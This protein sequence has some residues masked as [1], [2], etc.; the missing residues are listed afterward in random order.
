MIGL[1]T[2]GGPELGIAL[3]LLLR[4]TTP[5]GGTI[6]LGGTRGAGG[7][8]FPIPADDLIE[9]PP[10]GLV[11]AILDAVGVTPRLTGKARVELRL[12]TGVE[13]ETLGMGG[14]V[15]ALGVKAA[16]WARD[17]GCRGGDAEGA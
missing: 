10:I 5:A 16:G 9:D 14:A 13:R 15:R 4:R 7:L 17:D 3:R 2:E 1:E 6:G 11:G 12:G 8:G